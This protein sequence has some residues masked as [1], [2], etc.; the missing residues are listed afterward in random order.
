MVVMDS[1]WWWWAMEVM[2]VVEKG[3]EQVRKKEKKREKRETCETEK[4]RERE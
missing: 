1:R 3:R 2:A 4:T